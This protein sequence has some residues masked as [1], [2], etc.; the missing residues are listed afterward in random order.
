MRWS[1]KYV[2]FQDLKQVTDDVSR[3]A[4]NVDT[5]DQEIEQLRAMLQAATVTSA[6][7][8]TPRVFDITGMDL[9]R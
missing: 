4:D 9:V 3:M 7:R 5:L 2:N 8:Q 6:Q 1:A